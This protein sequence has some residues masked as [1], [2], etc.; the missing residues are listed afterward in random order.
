MLSVPVSVHQP[1]PDTTQAVWL[2]LAPDL[3]RT[4]STQSHCVD[5]E[6]Q[7]TDLAVG[8]VSS[9]ERPVDLHA[10][11]APVEGCSGQLTQADGV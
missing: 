7:P 9:P 6:H 1:S 2:D 3:S 11:V 4:D 10:D 8:F 5:A